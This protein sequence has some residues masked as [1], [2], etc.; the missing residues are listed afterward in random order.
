MEK[1]PPGYTGFTVSITAAPDESGRPRMDYPI[2]N[3]VLPDTPAAAAG[4]RSGD[5]ILAVNGE[6]A[7]RAG[8]LYPLVG[9]PYAMRIKRGDGE[10]EVSLIPVQKPARRT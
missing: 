1:P 5:V 10:R 9:A 4:L 2:I 8:V 3:D 7:R 6:D